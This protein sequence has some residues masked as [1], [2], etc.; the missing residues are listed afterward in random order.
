VGVFD[1]DMPGMDGVELIRHVAER[2]LASA[3]AIASKGAALICL[4]ETEPRSGS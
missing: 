2:Q 3:V 1:I 4:V